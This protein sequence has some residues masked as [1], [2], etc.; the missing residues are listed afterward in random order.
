MNVNKKHHRHGGTAVNVPML[1]SQ[2][3]SL[4]AII[5]AARLLPLSK[6]LLLSLHLHHQVTNIDIIW[7]A[8]WI[9][10]HSAIDVFPDCWEIS[11]ILLTA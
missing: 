4:H 7:Q 2:S 11:D 9:I 5:S 3:I 8:R 10:G 1:V 6:K